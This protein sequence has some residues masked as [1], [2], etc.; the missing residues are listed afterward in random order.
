VT[1]PAAGLSQQ[2]DVARQL[3][4]RASALWITAAEQSDGTGLGID[5]R[6]NLAHSLVD[7]SVKGFV[8]LLQAAI[9]GPNFGAT[10]TLATDPWP[11]EEITVEAQPYPRALA[12]TD[13][14]RIGAPGRTVPKYCIAFAP[15]FL[16]AGITT[17]RIILKDSSFV[18]S[19]FTGKITL[20]AMVTTAA[21]AKP[22]EKVVTV[23]L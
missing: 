22:E 12:A 17:F 8:A 10:A 16:P 19:N 11:S 18:G 20:T 2:G 6:I 23:G 5:A 3:I 4:E 9:S 1:T 7:L 13:F 21:A 15:E 14:E